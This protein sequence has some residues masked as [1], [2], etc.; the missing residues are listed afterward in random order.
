MVL[1]WGSG[2]GLASQARVVEREACGKAISWP[3]SQESPERHSEPGSV[4]NIE[5]VRLAEQ[6]PLRGTL[7]GRGAVTS[8]K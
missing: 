8:G 2:R 7:G 5:R 4:E 6:A 3:L 1:E